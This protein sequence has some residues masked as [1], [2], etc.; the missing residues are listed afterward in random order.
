MRRYWI[1]HE[2]SRH[3]LRAEPVEVEPVDA[4]RLRPEQQRLLQRLA[5]EQLEQ[6]VLGRRLAL[7]ELREAAVAHREQRLRV[8][9]EA[10]DRVAVARVVAEPAAAGHLPV[11]ELDERAHRALHVVRVVDPEHRPLVRER[12]LRD[13]PAAV[14]R[15][16]EV[17]LRARARR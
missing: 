9:V 7:Q 5:A 10:R 4:E 6:R 15:T 13:R 14:E 17:L 3:I 1:A 8:D 2:P 12:A 11:A 16:D